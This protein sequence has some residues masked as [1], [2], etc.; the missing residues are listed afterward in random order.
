MSMIKREFGE[1]IKEL[2]EELAIYDKFSALYSTSHGKF[3][4]EILIKAIS[5]TENEWKGGLYSVKDE[6][7]IEFRYSVRSKLQ[8][9]KVLLNKLQTADLEKASIQQQLSKMEGE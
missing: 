6:A 5:D 8:T 2:N 1:L 3:L 4:E 7:L 9:L